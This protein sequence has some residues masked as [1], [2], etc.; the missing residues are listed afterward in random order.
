MRQHCLHGGV[1]AQRGGYEVQQRS[2]PL[3]PQAG[4]VSVALH[5]ARSAL[6]R[7]LLVQRAHANPVI[8]ALQR[9]LQI[10]IGFQFNHREPPICGGGEQI[11]HA[12]VCGGKGLAAAITL[13]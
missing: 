13:C 1:Y 11:E 4:K 3:E 10:L 2:G 12:A 7:T 6:L 9:Q 8:Q 5:F